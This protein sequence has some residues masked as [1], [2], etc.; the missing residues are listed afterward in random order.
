MYD[1]QQQQLNRSVSEY[2]GSQLNQPD[3][4]AQMTSPPL[5]V[6]DICGELLLLY[7]KCGAKVISS[8]DSGRQ[9]GVIQGR[10]RLERVKRI[11]HIKA[12]LTRFLSVLMSIHL[13][14]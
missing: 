7:L 1:V 3:A 13:G 9:R 10:L 11:I 2:R 8:L 12:P 5:H 6:G 14:L 4:H